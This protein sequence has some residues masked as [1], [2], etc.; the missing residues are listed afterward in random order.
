MLQRFSPDWRAASLCAAQQDGIAHLWEVLEFVGTASLPEAINRFSYVLWF[1]SSFLFKKKRRNGLKWWI[2]I[3]FFFFGGAATHAVKF[4]QINSEYLVAS[5]NIFHSN[6]ISVSIRLSRCKLSLF[7]QISAVH[8]KGRVKKLD[9]EEISSFGF[10]L[11]LWICRFSTQFFRVCTPV[12][13][14]DL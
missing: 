6:P 12:W 13:T 7:E 8:Q 4:M 5:R 9:F 2:F 14:L 11:W 10:K 1:D 3:L